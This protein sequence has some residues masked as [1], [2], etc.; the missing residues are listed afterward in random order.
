M[1]FKLFALALALMLRGLA[2]FFADDIPVDP[3]LVVM[4]SDIHIGAKTNKPAYAAV[5]KAKL[6]QTL[7]KILAMNPRPALVLHYGDI[8]CSNGKPADYEMVKPILSRLDEA[9]IPWVTAFGNHDRRDA[10]WEVFPEKRG[11]EEFPERLVTVTETDRAFFILLDSLVVGSVAANPD[12]EQLQWLDKKLRSLES[13]GKRV[14]VGAH[15]PIGQTG[16]ADSLKKHPNAAGYIFGH[17]HYWHCKTVDSV[18]RVGLPSTAY[19]PHN[20]FPEKERPL[21]YVTLRL[22]ETEDVFTFHSRLENP[23]DGETFTVRF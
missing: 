17:N 15:H 11:V 8:A 19:I 18:P 20:K 14:Y 7:D 6:N 9:G 3:D 5:V 23:R 12:P 1:R 22:G 16:A 21:G 4:I 13:T 2:P 10:F